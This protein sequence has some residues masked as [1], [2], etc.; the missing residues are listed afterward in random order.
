MLIVSAPPWTAHGRVEPVNIRLHLVTAALVDNL[1]AQR[2]ADVSETVSGR[3]ER[4]PDAMSA[5]AEHDLY[6]VGTLAEDDD[7]QR[8]PGLGDAYRDFFVVHGFAGGCRRIAHLACRVFPG[9][10]VAD[11]T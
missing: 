1:A 7:I 6:P 9:G 2:V 5:C 4:A 8:L 11:L 3:R 10:S